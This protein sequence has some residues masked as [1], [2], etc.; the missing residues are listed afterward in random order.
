M[1]INMD[2]DMNIDMNID[3]D[4]I[5][6][7]MECMNISTKLSS[8][9][10]DD[11]MSCLTMLSFIEE[12]ENFCEDNNIDKFSSL[13]N[14]S[15]NTDELFV[16][17]TQLNDNN[18]N[19]NDNDNAN[20]NTQYKVYTNLEETHFDLPCDSFMQFNDDASQNVQ[21]GDATSCKTYSNICDGK[22]SCSHCIKSQVIKIKND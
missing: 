19:D 20:Q 1:S 14:L 6:I 3:M 22:Y 9:I 15:N 12:E 16:H 5:N 10:D 21:Y 4:L 11:N 7:D 2:I 13:Q 8:I 17:S 18:D